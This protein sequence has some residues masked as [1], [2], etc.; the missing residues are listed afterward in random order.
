MN[1]LRNICCAF[2]LLAGS[3]LAAQHLQVLRGNP[4][5]K[6][7]RLQ[8]PYVLKSAPSA[9]L[10]TLP[11]F[12]DFSSPEV[13]PDPGKWADPYAFINT[14][15]SRDPVSIGV[16]TLDAIDE[17]GDVYAL[18]SWPASSDMLTSLPFDLS[19]YSAPED[20]VIMSFFYQSGGTGEVPELSDSLLLEFFAPTDNQWRK[21]WFAI[22]DTAS[23]F[24]QVILPV[25]VSYYQSGFRFR[26]RN[27]TSLSPDEVAGGDGAVSNADCWNIDYIMLNTQPASAHQIIPDIA[28]MEPPRNLM[29]FYEAVPW[30]HLNDAQ[31]ITR[32]YMQYVFRNLQKAEIA[33]MGRN[34]YTK[35][36]GNGNSEYAQ[37]FYDDFSAEEIIRRND[38]FI[39]PFTRN[40]DSGEGIIEVAGYLITPEGQHKENDTAKIILHFKDYY[41]Y[42]DGT[43]EYGFGISGP[44]M[45]GALLAYRF[46]IYKADTLRALDMYFNKARD[47]Y[48][49]DLGFNLCVWKDD[50]GKPG[51][52]IYL[53]PDEFTPDLDTEMPEFK[54]YPISID[55]DLVVT[56]TSIYV[57]WKQVTDEFLNLGYDINRDNISRIFV[58]T[59]GEWFNPGSSIIPGSLMIRP[60]FGSKAV[61]TGSAEIPET[62][63]DIVLYPNPASSKVFIRA[64]GVVVRRIW[65]YDLYGRLVLQ[66]QDHS[67]HLDVS[68]FQSGIYEVILDTDQGSITR[69]IIVLN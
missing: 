42:D 6:M 68:G 35:N 11:F 41:A 47:N 46:R 15:F 49:A 8:H 36:L 28:I 9:L 31:S 3:T 58:N 54:R 22:L 44:S 33:N 51:E 56:D 53:A 60:V 34:Y 19:P 17:N 63:L 59:S 67:D 48:N 55:T 50:G 16:A 13:F 64:S 45:E 27:Y 10:L 24:Q 29:D 57:G 40:D 23:L 7:Y 26:F 1:H 4:V 65:V 43:P 18:T 21:E 38:P 25:P 12:E 32:N 69:K 37:E 52:L 14:S 5:I 66:Q 20:T 61:I 2:I 39:T 62:P 30:L